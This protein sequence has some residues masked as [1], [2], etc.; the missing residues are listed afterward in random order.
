MLENSLNTTKSLDNIGSVSVEVP[1]LTI[2]TLRCPPE[3]V[4]LHLLVDLELCASS[5]TLVETER[6]SVLLEEGVDTR[7]TTVPTVLK[8]LK[9]QAAV[10]LLSF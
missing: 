6:A 8:I 7:K 1:E 10:L 2:V 9:S 5:E 4:A 3:W